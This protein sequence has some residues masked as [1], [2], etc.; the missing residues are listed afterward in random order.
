MSTKTA[1][2]CAASLLVGALTGV[3]APV[4]Q[5][6]PGGVVISELNYHAAS[7][8][9]TD[10]FLELAN[11]SSSPVDISGWS[12][13]AG[14]TAVMPAGTSI[15]AGGYFVLSPSATAFQAL[16][17]FAP[18]G[19]YTG[20]L[21]NSGEAVTLVDAT[22]VVVDTVTYADLAPWPS[23]P[24]G[25]GPSLELRGLMF[26]NTLPDNWGP[27]TVTGGT[28]KAV[29]SIDGTAPPPK[30]TAV[31]ATPQRPAPGENVVVTAS[32][33]A[34]AVATMTYKV[35]FG[36]ETTVPFL[37]DEASPGGP[38]DGVYAATV[39]GQA[40]GALVR[41]RIDASYSGKA[42][43]SPA[44]D[45][46]VRYNGVVVTNP[47]VASQLP[48]I[49]WFMDDAV[50]NDVLA[51]HRYDDYQ[52]D[53]VIAYAGTVYDGVKMN[54][55]GQSSR[56]AAKVSWK[57]EMAPGH[58]M[59]FRPYMPYLLDEWALQ[60]DLDA[61][62]DVGWH[63]VGGAGARDVALQAIRTQRNGQFWS[64]GHFLQTEDGIWREA[65]GVKKWAIYKGDSGSLR[66]FATAAQLQASL[67]LDKKTRED[68]DFSDVWM[69][70]QWANQGVSP[71][72][73]SWFEANL[74]I[75]EIVNYMAVL[76]VVRHT[77]SG[78][79]NWYIVRDTEGTGRWEMWHWDLNLTFR[80]PAQDGGGAFLTPEK[81]NFLLN[82][83]LSYPDYRAMYFRRLRT[84]TDKFLAPGY[85][86]SLYDTITAPFGN[87]VALDVAK[88]GGSN[89]AQLRT[90]F[91][92]AVTERRTTIASA[93][94]AGK[95]V[96]V[97]QSATPS[98]VI[99][100][101]M[102]HPANPDAEYLELTNPTA[103]PIDL[104]GWALDGVDYTFQPG[105]VLLP[106][107]RVV[108]VANDVAFRAAYPGAVGVVG[109]YSGRLAD[110]G[111][112][113][114]LRQGDQVVDS[115][116]YA[117]GGDWPAEAAGGGASL[118]LR[119]PGMDNSLASS[120]GA[121]SSSGSPGAVNG[122]QPTPDTTP[123]AVV[124]GVLAAATPTGVMITW[125][126]ATDDRT[127]T[128]YH[129]LRNGVQIATVGLVGSFHD[130]S[131]AAGTSYD[132]AVRAVDRAG[133]VGPESNQVSAIT[134]PDLVVY[135]G[136]FT[137]ADGTAWPAP[138]MPE[139]YYGSATV[140]NGAG[141]LSVTNN[142]YADAREILDVDDR[143][144]SEL[145]LSYR[146]GSGGPN[147]R[148]SVYMRASSGW[149]GG[150]RPRHGVGVE[151]SNTSTSVLVKQ[152]S[153]SVA[154]TLQTIT[155][156][157]STSTTTKQWLRLR[158]QGATLAFKI[159]ADG[160]PEPATWRSSSTPT[161][162]TTPGR[163]Y[164]SLYRSAAAAAGSKTVVVDDVTYKTSYTLAASDSTPPTA[165]TGLA[166]AS[167]AS[168]AVDLTWAAATD[169][170][171]VVR[172]EVLRNG[173]VV[174]ESATT[175]YTDT[176][177]SP[178]T[179]YT[180][181]VRA[182]DA[183]SN[184]SPDSAALAVTTQPPADTTPPSAPTNLAA[185]SVTSS[186][187]VLGWT[188][189]T[190]DRGVTG[191]RIYRDGTQV[192][193]STTT[194]FTDATVLSSTTYAYAVRA[195]DAAGNLGPASTSLSVTTPP[196]VGPLYSDSFTAADGSPWASAWTTSVSNGA[197]DIRSNTGRLTDADAPS[198]YSRAIL[199]GLAPRA[200]SGVTYSYQWTP[201]SGHYVSMYLRAS[202]GWKDGF[203]PK[204]GY[205]I[206]VTKGATVTMYK[207]VNG[208]A[209]RMAQVYP[210]Q[211][212]TT[213]KQWA[214][215]EVV[216]STI[217]FKTWLD[218]KPEPAA[219][220]YSVTDTSVTSPGQL[221][222]SLARSSGTGYGGSTVSID[223]VAVTEATP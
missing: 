2:A 99:N 143:S 119:D 205:G 197:V 206:E 78:W 129:V 103:E 7:D 211:V 54:I 22:G 74:N 180:Y 136:D 200:D 40:A 19:I 55:K 16:H 152:M 31:T 32:F 139:L 65:E 9:D 82:A 67:D 151:V 53:A 173:G 153:N 41:Y 146:W 95:P 165:P 15:P 222:T 62:V 125:N 106:G 58:L 107:D 210:G 157:Q 20:K 52:A 72:Q 47:A 18:D 217:R 66:T 75:P 144:D 89:L 96:P 116:T 39:P 48:V 156:A 191:Y 51:N 194:A 69:L 104:S 110:E 190:D 14:V 154:S 81:S 92:S 102:Y 24:D 187:V 117:P 140:S 36:A 219:W 23:T 172:Y 80:S 202:G 100:E 4:A 162:V 29:N 109:Q 176:G 185:S 198:S 84:L 87:D 174:G 218:G 44:A 155:A 60:A 161:V 45:D 121:S 134:G 201:A 208:T 179:A 113:V 73:K 138:W 147:A 71:A 88:W 68:E 6:Q 145:L 132:Y 130:E 101:I 126:Q 133:N 27:S 86:E 25:T 142:T 168:T 199:S 1:L 38:G 83:L 11:T 21:S 10:D 77:D 42:F 181:T 46:S 141:V 170:I 114:S 188:A 175:S 189:A 193:T 148:F 192:G 37:D 216:G 120:W 158:V 169:N 90:R 3:T 94:G 163:P 115:V 204:N 150:A 171:G 64:L 122:S 33:Q 167:V 61:N 178:S 128:G 91:V 108:V 160:T 182:V 220:T 207:V 43:S 214:R 70:T 215:L 17:G 28:P 49:E 63:T 135:R 195:Q 112:T 56:S 177:L 166:A 203:K 131:V 124:S 221:Y 35:G 50:Y 93:T 213:A 76:T 183:S 186:S 123:P 137:G 97:S 118:E 85:Y 79:R 149:S 13:S 59:D 196:S 127:V 12:F 98:A 8:L 223:D 159:W 30:M 105:T 111:E 164:L 209:T 57:V 184:V 212:V 26:D 34:G 5:A